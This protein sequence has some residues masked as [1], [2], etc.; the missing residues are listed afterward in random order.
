MDAQQPVVLGVDY[1]AVSRLLRTVFLV[2]FTVTRWLEHTAWGYRH[3]SS[4]MHGSCPS[5]TMGGMKRTPTPVLAGI[6]ILEVWPKSSRLSVI[7][8]TLLND[9]DKE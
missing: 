7:G 1:T 2:V 9:L 5:E 6:P 3:R 8:S 4:L